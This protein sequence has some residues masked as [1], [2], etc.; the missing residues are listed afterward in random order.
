M[1]NPFTVVNKVIPSRRNLHI[2]F[3]LLMAKGKDCWKRISHITFATRR[4]YYHA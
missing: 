2:P 3:N 1:A 4:H